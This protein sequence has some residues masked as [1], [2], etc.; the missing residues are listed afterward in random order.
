MC[1]LIY[2]SQAKL[3]QLVPDLP[4]RFGLRDVEAEVTTPVGGLK[5]GKAA[6]EAERGLAAAVTR[7]EASDRAPIWFAEPGIRPG[8]WV[9]FEA[10]MS[11]GDADGAVF[12]L[13]TEQA[14]ELYP[15]GGEL[16]LLLHSSSAHL[17]GP[18][19]PLDV[20]SFASRWG[21]FLEVLSRD[22][23]DGVELLPAFHPFLARVARAMDRLTDHLQPHYTSAWVAG[24][25]RVTAVI[26]INT[27]TLLAATPLYVEHIAAPA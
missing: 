24:Y 26:P 21:R 4:G 9:Q 20:G 13:D 12:F 14:D 7:L 17:I 11:Y 6:R 5:L 22:R 27:S 1:E 25:A 15:S 19:A 16:R 23:E 8:Q 3:R 10:P 2:V 18:A